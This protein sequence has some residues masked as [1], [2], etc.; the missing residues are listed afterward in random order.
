MARFGVVPSGAPS[1]A[2]SPGAVSPRAGAA[3]TTE[4]AGSG[5]AASGAALSGPA[6]L[7]TSAE[8]PPRLALAMAAMDP[9]A[10]SGESDEPLEEALRAEPV[11]RALRSAVEHLERAGT[12]AQVQRICSYTFSMFV[13]WNTYA[14]WRYTG[15]YPLPDH[16]LTHSRRRRPAAGLRRARPR[17]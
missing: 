8:L 14:A 16:I 2:V 5:P 4:T 1:I 7:G 17:P 11:L 9:L 13:S 12:P 15:E 6:G 10:P 3:A